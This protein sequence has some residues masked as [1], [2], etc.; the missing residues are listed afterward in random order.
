MIPLS[1]TVRVW[2]EN[3][4][5]ATEN[6]RVS[7][8]F[9]PNY[10]DNGSLTHIH[11]PATYTQQVGHASVASDGRKQLNNLR[12]TNQMSLG[13]ENYSYSLQRQPQRS[14]CAAQTKS[15]YPSHGWRRSLKPGG[16]THWILEGT[17]PTCFGREIQLQQHTAVAGLRER[18]RHLASLIL[19]PRSSSVAGVS[20]WS[21][22]TH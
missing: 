2:H 12:K 17:F 5:T 10:Q 16:V 13:K 21:K 15:K 20:W 1:V 11:S 14:P 19:S 3:V 6:S 9:Q 8:K 22:Q 4:S 18:R 7:A